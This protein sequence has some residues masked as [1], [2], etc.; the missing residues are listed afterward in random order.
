VLHLPTQFFKPTQLRGVRK[1]VVRI[2]KEYARQTTLGALTEFLKKICI[3]VSGVEGTAQVS[4]FSAL[5]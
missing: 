2:R 3:Q 4:D 1:R 5:D